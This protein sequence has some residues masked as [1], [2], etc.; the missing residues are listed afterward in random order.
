MKIRR[1]NAIRYGMLAA[2]LVIGLLSLILA[3]LLGGEGWLR[4]GFLQPRITPTPAARPAATA[5]QVRVTPAPTPIQVKVRRNYPRRAVDVRA[6]GRLLFTAENPQA[7]REALERY[8]REIASLELAKNERLLRAA[9]DQTITLEEPCGD[10]ELLQVEEAV[11][12][13]RADEGLL[14]VSRTVVRCVIERGRVQ[15][16]VRENPLLAEGSRIYRSLGVDPFVLS[17]FE[18]IYRGQAAFSE[19]RT[20]EFAVGQG[21]ADQ[22]IENGA[23]ALGPAS[24]QAGPAAVIVEGFSPQWPVAG[25]VETSFGLVDGLPHY[26]VDIAAQSIA[27]VAAPAEG[28]VVF[29][30]Q[31]GQ[32]GLV[33]DILHDETGCMSRIIGCERPLVELYQRVRKGEQV[34]VLPEPVG[35]GTVLL[36]YELLV[37]GLPVNPEKY[38]PRK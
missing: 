28:V 34:G 27:R 5:A 8:L 16:Q 4:L 20:N 12:T 32:L 3:L 36:R 9:I 10:G 14:P 29:C 23:L 11:H 21:K 22:V 30:G 1:E 17:Y 18:T 13:L 2:V 24:A 6:D 7:A 33:I 25:T 38:L 15:T 26:G 37:G 35:K 19:V 31:R